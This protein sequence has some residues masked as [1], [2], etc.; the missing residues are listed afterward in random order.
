[1]QN[2]CFPIL[3]LLCGTTTFSQSGARDTTFITAAARNTVGKYRQAIGVQAKL[4][5]GSKYVPPE[6]D[7]DEHPYFL[8]DDWLMGNVYYDDELFIDVPLMYDLYSGQLITEHSAS[9]HANWFL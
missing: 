2:I 4:N 6:Q 9:G 7:V 5:N 8:S 1:M 3:L